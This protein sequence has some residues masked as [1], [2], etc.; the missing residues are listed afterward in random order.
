MI[1]V[2]RTRLPILSVLGK[3]ILREICL[4]E[5]YYHGLNSAILKARIHESRQQIEFAG[6]S[7]NKVETYFSTFTAS[8]KTELL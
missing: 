1:L 5:I 4:K 3:R 6:R 2:D 7:I 8:N